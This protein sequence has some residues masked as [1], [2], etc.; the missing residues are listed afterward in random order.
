MTWFL[1]NKLKIYEMGRYARN[2]AIR[3]TWE[4]YEDNVVAAINQV[5][6]L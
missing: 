3:Y 2:K 4:Y 1:E 5:L 6:N